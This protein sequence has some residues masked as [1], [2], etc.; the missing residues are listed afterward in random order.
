MWILYAA[1]LL[2]AVGIVSPVMAFVFAWRPRLGASDRQ[3]TRRTHASGEH[4]SQ[5]CLVAALV[6]ARASGLFRFVD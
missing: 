3:H 4:Q 5:L 2:W 1:R 6:V